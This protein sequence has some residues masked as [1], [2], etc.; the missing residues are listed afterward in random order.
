MSDQQYNDPRDRDPLPSDPVVRRDRSVDRMWGW[1]A[2]IAVIVLIA[3]ILVA[4]WNTSGNNNTASNNPPPAATPPSTTGQAPSI[5][6]PTAP[7]ANK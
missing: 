7:P 5:P 6:A 2:G 1:I 3:F 4:G